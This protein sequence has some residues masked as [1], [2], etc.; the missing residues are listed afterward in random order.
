MELSGSKGLQWSIRQGF[1]KT[2]THQLIGR[3]PTPKSPS[4]PARAI[5]ELSGHAN[6]STTQRCM[7]LS[8]AEIESAIRLVDQPVS[9][10]MRGAIGEEERTLADSGPTFTVTNLHTEV[11]PYR[12]PFAASLAARSRARSPASTLAIE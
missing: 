9:D 6:L 7:H 2:F 10:R 11:V 5:Q 8:P 4:P 1:R 12:T 3:S